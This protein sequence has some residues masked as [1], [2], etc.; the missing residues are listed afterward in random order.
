[1]SRA[2]E[3]WTVGD[4]VT[5]DLSGAL[6]MVTK[7]APGIAVPFVASQQSRSIILLS[8]FPQ[9]NDITC[10]TCPPH[11][12]RALEA[13]YLFRRTHTQPVPAHIHPTQYNQAEYLG[14]GLNN[15]NDFRSAVTPSHALRKLVRT[16]LVPLMLR[17]EP[18]APV[19]KRAH[20]SPSGI[21]LNLK[22]ACSL[23]HDYAC[24]CR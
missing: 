4:N 23:T 19:K 9:Q 21:Q 5:R 8:C 24:R 16:A 6:R 10:G 18:H 17:N 14:F 12:S 2:R 13:R 22:I 3:T 7:D 20:R 11:L 15:D 1:M